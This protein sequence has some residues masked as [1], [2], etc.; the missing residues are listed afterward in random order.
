MTS[1]SKDNYQP[2]SDRPDDGGSSLVPM[3]I[4]GLILVVIGYAAIMMFV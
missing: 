3:L 4:A 1:T 2:K